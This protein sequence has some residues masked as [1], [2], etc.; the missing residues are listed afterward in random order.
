MCSFDELD[1]RSEG[2]FTVINSNSDTDYFISPSFIF[3]LERNWKLKTL[4]VD[5]TDVSAAMLITVGPQVCNA[6]TFPPLMSPRLFSVV[7]EAHWLLHTNANPNTP[8]KRDLPSQQH[9]KFSVC[10]PPKNETV[11]QIIHHTNKY[12]QMNK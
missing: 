11:A 12:V 9:Y 6:I 5:M 7:R 1:Y 3:L 10:F 8:P 2:R 4:L